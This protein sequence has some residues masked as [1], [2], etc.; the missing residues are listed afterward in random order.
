MTVIHTGSGKVTYKA[1]RRAMGRQPYTMSL[2]D[3]TEIRAVVEAVNQGI[4]AHLEACYC[5]DRG[6]S[7]EGGERRAGKLVLCRSLDCVVSVESLP[8]LLR[9]LFELDT[10]DDVVDAAMSLGGDI[11]LTLGFDECGQFVGR[12]AVGLA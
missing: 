12:E 3:T 10:T 2:T 4:D 11:L 1:V 5:P 9:R 8:V 7:Y 6:D